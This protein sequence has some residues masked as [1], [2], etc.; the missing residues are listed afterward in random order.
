MARR[1]ANRFQRIQRKLGKSLE[2]LGPGLVTGAA[3]DDPSGIATYSQ[4]GA[5]FGY[6]LLWTMV[7]MYPLMSAVQLVSA[8]IGR[9][10]GAGLASNLVGTFPRRV[11]GLL[12]AILAVANIIN[13]GAD[14]SAMAASAELVAGGASHLF[15]VAFALVSTMLQLFVPYR[16]YARLLK[17]LTLSLFAYVGVLLVVRTDWPAAITGLVVPGDLGRDALLTIVALFGTTISPYLFFWQSS[18]EAEE[19]SNSPRQKPIRQAPRG[20]VGQFRRMRVDTLVGMA[21]SNL[22]AIAIIMATAATLHRQGITQIDSAAQAAE[23]LRPVAGS[24]AF[25]LFAIGIIGTGFLA[26]PVLAG[27][28]AFAVAETF[29]WSEGLE[30]QPRQ[31]AGFYSIIVL[32]T[33]LGLM[34]DWS[35]VDPIR[36]LFWSAVLNGLAAVPLM[37]AMMI[38]VSR[39]KVMGRFTASRTL[40][41]LGWTA[42]AI[43]GV[44]CAA[45]LVGLVA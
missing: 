11:V 42:T 34:I 27:S 15:V 10:T 22:I 28:T 17:W 31:A 40:L 26:V 16:Q 20:A 24:F 41:L 39:H 23:A 36:A 3:D 2:Q 1:P 19:I 21:F 14:L 13:I 6:G 35:P 12:V 43:M 5:Q 4:A 25:A 32:A 7:L 45:M 44:V 37:V 8:H 33:V 30:R 9:V 38:V 18:Q 29:G